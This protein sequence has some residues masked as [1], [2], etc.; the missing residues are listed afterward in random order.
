MSVVYWRCMGGC[1]RRLERQGYCDSCSPPE[2]HELAWTGQ[3][4]LARELAA[5]TKPEL[6]KRPAVDVAAAPTNFLDEG[7][8]RALKR[9][10][11]RGAPTHYN[12]E[13]E[14]EAH[15]ERETLAARRARAGRED[16]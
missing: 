16:A 1:D 7:L 14:N 10:V 13:L 5:R 12:E 15:L 8:M 3:P 6:P 2:E 9:R 11:H 4:E